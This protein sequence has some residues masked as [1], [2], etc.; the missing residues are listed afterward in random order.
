MR[1]PGYRL[2]VELVFLRVVIERV[3]LVVEHLRITTPLGR[4]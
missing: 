3:P 2:L 4:A 1:P